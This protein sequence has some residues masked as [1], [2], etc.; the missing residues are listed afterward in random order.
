MFLNNILR[1]LKSYKLSIVKILFYEIFYILIGYKGN[2]YSFSRKKDIAD[3]IPCPY[4]FLDKISVIVKKFKLK[5]FFDFGCGSG[6]VINFFHQK[7]LFREYQG[8]EI[9]DQP[10]NNSLR[11]FKKKKNIKIIKSNFKKI[12]IKKKNSCFFFNLPFAKEN[13]F[14]DYLVANK[15]LIFEKENIVILV[16]FNQNVLHRLNFFKKISKYY[17]AEKKGFYI[18]KFI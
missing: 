5:Y 7:S 11:L 16:N 18:C 6:R 4:L 10:Y 13:D 17:V 12:K 2:N 8:Y 14:I 3:N 9:F 15:N 1:I